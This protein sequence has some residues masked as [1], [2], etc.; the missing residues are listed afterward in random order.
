MKRRETLPQEISLLKPVF[1]ARNLKRTFQFS[2]LVGK[3]EG[4]LRYC[5]LRAVPSPSLGQATPLPLHP[6]H[7]S[8][9]VQQENH[10]V[11]R[12]GCLPG[13]KPDLEAGG[14]GIRTLSEASLPGFE[15]S[16]AN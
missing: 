8:Q 11:G 4:V 14:M 9:V 5:S 16:D 10:R 2:S 12:L 7:S 6:H 15:S 1:V 13:H 3:G